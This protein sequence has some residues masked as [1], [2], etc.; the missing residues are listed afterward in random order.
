MKTKNLSALDDFRNISSLSKKGNTQD[1]NADSIKTAPIDL[2]YEDPKNSRLDFDEE[3]L[4]E[5][6]ATM[7]ELDEN[8]KPRGILEPVSV[9]HHPVIENAFMING[10]HRRI[11]AAK[12]AGITDVPYYI[13]NDYS[14]I[15]N[16]LLNMYVALSA[17][18]QAAFIIDQVNNEGMTA[19]NLAKAIGKS[20]SFISDHLAFGEL[21]TYLR[22]L[23]DDGLCKSIQALAALH[24]ADKKFP[25]SV[26]QFCQNAT[27]LVSV[28]EAKEFAKGLKTQ[29][30]QETENLPQEE[31]QGE[32]SQSPH[33]ERPLIN[34]VATA[35]VTND[36]EAETSS[37]KDTKQAHK[38]RVVVEHKGAEGYILAN[39][40]SEK[41]G[42]V[43][44][45]FSADTVQNPDIDLILASELTV[46]G[47]A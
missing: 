1:S 35:D 23:H 44:I 7:A 3:Q 15:D 41:E 22:K 18:E 17:E 5:L 27:K 24:R 4:M 28:G 32:P 6:A 21:S 12:I 39:K 31:E 42:F 26:E 47:I 46:K 13:R 45:N 37:I 40:V 16:Y 19:S 8:G 11:R 38:G 20:N 29:K 34:D 2:F 9:R 36:D 30:T 10:G 14:S 25:E 43:W 33:D